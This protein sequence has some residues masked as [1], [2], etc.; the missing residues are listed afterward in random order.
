MTLEPLAWIVSL[1]NWTGHR[2]G[3]GLGPPPI[4][5]ERFADRAEAEARKRA[6]RQQ[7][8]DLDTV[9]ICVTAA[10]ERRRKRHR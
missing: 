10:S 9:L 3:C 2:S 7:Y 4:T 1:Q 6:L 5:T 8:A